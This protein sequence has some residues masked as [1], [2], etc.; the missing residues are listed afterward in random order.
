MKHVLAFLLLALP[1][2]AAERKFGWRPSPHGVRGLALQSS[3][4]YMAAPLPQAASIEQWFFKTDQKDRGACVAFTA[5]ECYSAA[6]QRDHGKKVNL[7]PLDIY[8]QCLVRDGSFPNDAGTYGGTAIAALLATG[9]MVEKTWPY[10]TPLNRLPVLTPYM[11][12]QRTKHKALKAYAIPN[13]DGGYAT[14]QAI[15]NLRIGV[16]IGT[17]WYGNQ[18]DTREVTVQTKDRN[19]NAT[20]VKR[21]IVDYPIGRPV[22]GHEIP[23]GAYD[24][25]MRFPDGSVGGAWIHNHWQGWGDDRGG[26]WASYRWVFNPRICE[27]KVAIEG[28]KK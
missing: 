17:Y 9:S 6:H 1:L 15:A 12:G 13:N 10:S 26:A 7:S 18:M 19:G 25:N 14:K 4:R 3:P 28:V 27:D 22:G 20:T 2:M 21:H 16:M 23:I 24:D 11:K 5:W 8:Q